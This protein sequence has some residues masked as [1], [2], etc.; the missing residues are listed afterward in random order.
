VGFGFIYVMTNEAMPTVVKVGRTD[1]HPQARAD[2]MWQHTGVP[3][4]F[5]V[6]CYFEVS[7]ALAAEN[8]IH[9]ALAERRLRPDREFFRVPASEA[10]ATI[11]SIARAYITAVVRRPSDPD[12]LIPGRSSSDECPICHQPRWFCKC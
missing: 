8:A 7:D 10:I 5:D 12:Y 11:E 2:E 6:V 1:R 3:V 9:T 4:P